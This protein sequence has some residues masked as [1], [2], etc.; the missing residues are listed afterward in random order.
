MRKIIK[1]TIDRAVLERA[2]EA[3]DGAVVLQAQHL[4]AQRVRVLCVEDYDA[5]QSELNA[6][7]DALKWALKLS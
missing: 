1:V 2:L 4:A 6:L 7:R 5:L 3:L